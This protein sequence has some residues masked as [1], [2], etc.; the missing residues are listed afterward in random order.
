MGHVCCNYAENQEG[1]S[2]SIETVRKYEERRRF[3]TSVGLLAKEEVVHNMQAFMFSEAPEQQAKCVNHAMVDDVNIEARR[4]P[5]PA[6]GKMRGYARE[7]NFDVVTSME[8]RSFTNLQEIKAAEESGDLVLAE[9]MTVFAIGW[10]AEE[11]YSIS[12]VGASGSAK[13]GA[14]AKDLEQMIDLVI[15]SYRADPK[16]WDKQ[17]PLSTVQTDGAAIMRL[18]LH[19]LCTK[20]K[21]LP[22]SPVGKALGV[23]LLFDYE[24]GHSAKEPIIAGCDDKHVGKRFRMAVKSLVRGIK[25]GQF[26]FLPKQILK[27]VGYTDAQVKEMFAEGNVDSQNVGAMTKL[28]HAIGSLHSKPLKEFSAARRAVPDFTAMHQSLAALSKYCMMF[29]EVITGQSHSDLV[30]LPLA[31]YLTKA[32]A[33]GHMAFSMYRENTTKFV[34]S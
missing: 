21:V 22:A 6:D 17:G 28:L 5:S 16:G 14:T 13:K 12:L 29:Y 23:L 33:L 19:K 27:E 7:S 30:F 4:R 34:P 20:Y 10:N 18:A 1:D 32:V 8:V 9:E 3:L 11:N 25:T 2:A 26:T 24:C 31:S 15:Q